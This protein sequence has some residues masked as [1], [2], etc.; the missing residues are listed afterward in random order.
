MDDHDLLTDSK[1]CVICCLLTGV[2]TVMGFIPMIFMSFIRHHISSV[3]MWLQW[4]YSHFDCQAVKAV[5]THSSYITWANKSHCAAVT[6]Q[7]WLHI[8]CIIIMSGTGCPIIWHTR[9]GMAY[10]L[11]A[12]KKTFP[13]CTTLRRCLYA[14][15]C[16]CVGVASNL[17]VSVCVCV[18]MP[19]CL[20]RH[21]VDSIVVFVKHTCI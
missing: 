5:I 8:I 12:R 1:K 15:V 10:I 7:A 13:V 20:K 16:V 3:V 4:W 19:A 21:M 6:L 18:C 2:E 11:T 9:G 14:L 17:C